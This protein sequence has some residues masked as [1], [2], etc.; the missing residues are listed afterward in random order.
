M[1]SA[2]RP[3]DNTAL[4]AYMTCP[5]EYYFSM[6]QH[7]R[8][9]IEKAALSFGTAWHKALEVWYKGGSE[10]DVIKA[11]L[12]AWQPHEGE[13][14][15]YRTAER[16]LLD[17]HKYI[18]D[19]ESP[20]AKAGDRE[21]TIGWPSQP[22][23]EISTAV[24]SPGLPQP[25]AG[26]IDRAVE[27]LKL[28]YC[29]DHKTTSRFDKYYMSQFVTSNQMKGYTWLLKQLLPSKQVVGVRVNLSHI[30]KDSTKFFR[31]S[32]LYQPDLIDEWEK[33][34]RRWL[35]RIYSDYL[36]HGLEE[37]KTP[38][39]LG[40]TDDFA[41]ALLARGAFPGH[42]GDNGCS[43]KFGLCQYHQV[44][45]I[46]PR[47]QQKVLEMEFDVRPWNPLEVDIE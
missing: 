10:A 9:K 45:S 20:G 25:Y 21:Q 47:L 6:V 7:R 43:R 2:G 5:R 3:V 44:C 28:V 18:N 35:A 33:N 15:D 39:E 17:F 46:S 29:E 8:S 38:A 34:T 40:L 30:L 27:E 37:G 11:V 12:D 41:E 22:M 1:D 19:P 31:Q 4:S 16:C 36:A 24:T 32:F 23:V 26:K 13:G 14:N 42:F